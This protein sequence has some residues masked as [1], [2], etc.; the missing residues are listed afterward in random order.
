M[1]KNVL[2]E[3][4]LCMHIVPLMASLSPDMGLVAASAAHVCPAIT[5][6]EQTAKFRSLDIGHMADHE[7][8]TNSEH[9]WCKI[10]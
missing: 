1:S 5:Q 7:H 9:L 8:K 6:F 4:L 10:G 2:T 3:L